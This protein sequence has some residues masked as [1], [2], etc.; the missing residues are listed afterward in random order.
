MAEGRV[1]ARRRG[2][3]PSTR[4]YEVDGALRHQLGLGLQRSL[5]AALM[6]HFQ[7]IA[8]GIDVAPVMAQLA[9][10]PELWNAHTIRKTAPGTPHSQMSDIFVRYND[11]TSFEAKGDYAGFNDIH[12]PVWYP[13]WR[14]LPA[15]RPIVFGLMSFVEG[16]MLGG[17]L[18][19]RIPPGCGIDRHRDDSWHVR[20]FEKFYVSVQ[21]APGA[22]FG[23][24]HD[25]V[26]EELEPKTG[27]CWLFDNKKTH[28]VENR[29]NVE[30]ITLI[31]CIRREQS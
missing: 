6:Q 14:A 20:T 26:I 10:H 15:L 21:S 27:E 16:E 30:R 5:S 7:K 31:V 24:E 17:V 25:G 9:E 18:I 2:S 22:I 11:V 3:Q 29:S 8:E 19:T 1:R 12:V 23:C 28:W 13:S 4:Q